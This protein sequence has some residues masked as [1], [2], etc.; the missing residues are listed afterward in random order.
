M[1][2]RAATPADYSVLADLWYDSWMSVGIANETDLDRAGVRTR[3]YHEA[4]GRWSLFAAE[5][6]GKI[7]GLLALVPE[8]ARIDQI[9]VEP[10]FKGAGVGLELLNFAKAHM[11]DGI[12]LTTHEENLRARAFY[13]REGFRLTGREPDERHRRTKCHYAWHP[14]G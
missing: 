2:V 14:G 7:T 8:E 9:F 1:S 5:D 13:G 12:V 3:F 11:P 10:A 4:A 6:G